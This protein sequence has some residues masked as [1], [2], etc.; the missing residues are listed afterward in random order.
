MNTME[1]VKTFLDTSTIHGM[2]WIS[3]TRR[4]ARF[5]W[6]LIVLG[7]FS[8]AGYMIHQSFYNWQQ[9][10]ITTTLE[11]LPISDITYPNITVCPPKNS[12]L[13]LNYDIMKSTDIKLNATTRKQLLDYAFHTTQDVFWEE[14]MLNFG[15]SK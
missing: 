6:I 14:L 1:H 11:T 13:N 9:S 12:F 3:S 10:P 7:G 2:S 8:W 15:I 4:F 5:F